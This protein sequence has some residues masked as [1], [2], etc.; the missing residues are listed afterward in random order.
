MKYLQAS[1]LCSSRFNI[2]MLFWMMLLIH[3]VL[4]QPTGCFACVEEERVALLEIKSAFSDHEGIAKP[5]SIFDYW[6]KSIECCSW[7]GVYCSPTMKHVRHLDLAFTLEYY[8]NNTLN[9]SMFLPFRE[10][11]SLV[12]SNNGFNSCIP[13]DCLGSLAKL[14][15]L[16]RLD[17]SSNKFYFMNGTVVHVFMLFCIS[18]VST[19]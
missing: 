19:C 1:L 10:L 11:R 2:L 9:V 17:L 7:Y 18:L 5:Y 14:D 6:N 15:S 3:H 4:Q 13:S 8:N 12:L 16:R